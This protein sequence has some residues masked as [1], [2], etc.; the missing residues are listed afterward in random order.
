VLT[1]RS[2][3]RRGWQFC[4]LRSRSCYS[5]PVDQ[6]EDERDRQT[7]EYGQRTRRRYDAASR[8]EANGSGVSGCV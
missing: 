4:R 7:E 3:A 6:T 5:A 2:G 8:H 1:D